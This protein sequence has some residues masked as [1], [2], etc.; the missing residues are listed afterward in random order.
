MTTLKQLGQSLKK[1]AEKAKNIRHR[2]NGE[3]QTKAYIIDPYLELLGYDTKNPAAVV[4]EFTADIAKG[5]EKVDYALLPRGESS[6]LIEAKSAS[7]KLSQ[8]APR[9]LQ[10]YFMAVDAA[11][12]AAYTNGFHWHWYRAIP[13]KLKLEQQPFLSLDVT[14][15]QSNE[16]GWLYSVSKANFELSR[17][18]LI[19]DEIDATRKCHQ[20][21]NSA[22][23]SPSDELIRTVSKEIWGS[24][25]KPSAT[26]I[27]NALINVL[28]QESGA[29]K[30]EGDET[31]QYDDDRKNHRSKRLAPPST[32][33]VR[34]KVFSQNHIAENWKQLMAMIRLYEKS[35]RPISTQEVFLDTEGSG[36]HLSSKR[37][38]RAW[39]N[40]GGK[41]RILDSGRD[42]QIE[43][44]KYLASV[45]K[46]GE[47]SYFRHIIK[48]YDEQLLCEGTK[49]HKYKKVQP[50]LLVFIDLTNPGKLITLAESAK[51]VQT[52]DNHVIRVGDDPE[53]DIQVW[54]PFMKNVRIDSS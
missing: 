14:E 40:K 13:G 32:R 36:S 17:L 9:Q 2:C 34:R 31:E 18:N 54:L 25:P 35:Q 11:E 45:D 52:S 42:V 20:W 27:R 23:S 38:R 6:V 53:A 15:P 48:L 33:K 41:W 30:I 5:N 37:T 3:T 7:S 22:K 39:R 49:K 8:E 12:F 4:L 21:L 28:N 26:V 43:V 46:R 10:R 44:M 24:T 51:H 50:N 16:L 19:A 29:D 1:F 47:W